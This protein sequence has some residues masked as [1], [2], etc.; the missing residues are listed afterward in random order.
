MEGSC[1]S[2]E[3]KGSHF[4]LKERSVVERRAERKLL[5]PLFEHSHQR[6][7]LVRFEHAIYAFDG[8]CVCD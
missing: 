8:L 2:K 3:E 1:W 6:H 4:V 5:L 7:Q